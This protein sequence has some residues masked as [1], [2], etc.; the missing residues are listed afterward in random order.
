MSLPENQS[1]YAEVR[2]PRLL[3]YPVKAQRLQLT[4][5]EYVEKSTGRVKLLR[6]EGLKSVEGRPA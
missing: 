2:I 1:S 3:R 5:S 6:F 4:V